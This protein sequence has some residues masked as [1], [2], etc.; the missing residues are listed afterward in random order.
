MYLKTVFN[1]KRSQNKHLVMHSGFH[2]TPFTLWSS[3][4]RIFHDY[5]DALLVICMD[6]LLTFSKIMIAT[7]SNFRPRCQDSGIMICTFRRRV[8]CHE[9]DVGMSGIRENLEK[10]KVWKT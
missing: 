7:T 8:L 6:D 1:M 4:R 10:V 3:K 2:N 5:V 9:A